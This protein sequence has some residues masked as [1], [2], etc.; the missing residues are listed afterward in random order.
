M[1][2][3]I[4]KLYEMFIYAQKVGFDNAVVY[5]LRTPPKLKEFLNILSIQIH[6]LIEILR[7]EW[8]ENTLNSLRS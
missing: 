7:H 2:V 8:T 3:K 6:Y 4:N 1:D 5:S